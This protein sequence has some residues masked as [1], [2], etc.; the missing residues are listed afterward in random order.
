MSQECQDQ[1]MEN[2]IKEQTQK[3]LHW[4][5]FIHFIKT[6]WFEFELCPLPVWVQAELALPQTQKALLNIWNLNMY[7]EF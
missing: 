1:A 3:I 6:E 4:V 2:Y 5:Y 7:S